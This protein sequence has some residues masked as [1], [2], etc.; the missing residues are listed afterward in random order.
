MIWKLVSGDDMSSS[1]LSG[2]VFSDEMKST[3]DTLSP[4]LCSLCST[5]K[6]HPS[7]GVFACAQYRT[8]I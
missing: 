8:D 5:V 3:L 2:F 4:A 6:A 1:N 7:R